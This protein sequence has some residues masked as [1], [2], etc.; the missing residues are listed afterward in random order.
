MSDPTPDTW[1]RLAAP[2]P[3]EAIRW[4]QQGKPV[5]SRRGG[6]VARFMPFITADQV[7]ERLEKVVPGGWDCTLWPLPACEVVD[8]ERTGE[9]VPVHAAICSLS[10]NGVTREGIGEGTSPKAAATDAL[11]RAA[12]LFGVGTDVKRIPI[13]WVEMHS[14]D[15][16][17]RPVKPAAEVYRTSRES[18][19]PRSH[20]EPPAGPESPSF[21]AQQFS[22]FNRL[23]GELRISGTDL[24]AMMKESGA[25]RWSALPPAKRAELVADLKRRHKQWEDAGRTRAPAAAGGAGKLF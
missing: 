6:H 1:Q 16:N 19:P 20:A 8:P 22:E 7:R 21:A 5:P 14:G 4:R 23:A 13:L 10:V 3:P 17:A 12:V 24:L 25:D 18:H 11:K 15:K 2:F 9:L